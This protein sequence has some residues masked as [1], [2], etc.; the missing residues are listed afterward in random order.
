MLMEGEW[1]KLLFE[2]EPYQD[3]FKLKSND[4][5]QMT[6][7]EHIIKTQSMLSKPIVRQAPQL[8][9][10]IAQWSRQLDGIQCTMDA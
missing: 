7:D 8:Q 2:L 10:R 9:A 5:M 1:K 6:L 3:T 4:V